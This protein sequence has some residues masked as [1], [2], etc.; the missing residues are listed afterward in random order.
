MKRI[1]CWPSFALTVLFT[2]AL[3]LPGVAQ[4]QEQPKDMVAF[5]I[6]V[7]S[8]E[9]PAGGYKI[10]HDPPIQVAKLTGKGEGTPIGAV[11]AIEHAI[12]RVAP[13]GTWHWWD[14]FGALTAANGDAIFF[15]YRGLM[16]GQKTALFIT[17]GQGRFRGATGH[18]T[19]TWAA[20]SA[21]GEVVCTFEGMISAPR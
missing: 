16:D 9:D 8:T 2:A 19:M 18:G 17:G 10:P 11:T 12:A 1:S 13:D 5:K 3:A 20:G 6:V 15:A 4:A 7:N 21:T 14:A